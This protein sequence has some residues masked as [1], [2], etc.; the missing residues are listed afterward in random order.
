[1][2]GKREIAN[3]IIESSSSSSSSNSKGKRGSKKGSI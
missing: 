1:M 3:K 2:V